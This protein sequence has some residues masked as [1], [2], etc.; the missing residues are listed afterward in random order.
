[1]DITFVSGNKNKFNELSDIFSKYNINLKNYN[2]VLLEIQ[3]ISV[4]K[5]IM[6]KIKHAYYIFQQPIIIE[7]S[8]LYITTPPMNG[9]P[10]ALIKNYYECLGLDGICEKNGGNSAYCETIIGYHNGK[11]IELFRGTIEGTIAK[12]P[13]YGDFGFGWDAIFIPKNNNLS[14]AQIENKNEISMR[15][16]AAEKLIYHLKKKFT[17]V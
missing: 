17:N 15:K 14:F 10:G 12:K 11:N 2:H 5:V 6:E 1:M 4:E 16:I 13:L 9:F 8:G 7:D 3:S